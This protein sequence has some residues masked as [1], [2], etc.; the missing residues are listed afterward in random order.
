MYKKTQNKKTKDKKF[1]FVSGESG[2][3]LSYEEA[4]KALD[5]RSGPPRG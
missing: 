4:L 2:A 3:G 5:T 1:M